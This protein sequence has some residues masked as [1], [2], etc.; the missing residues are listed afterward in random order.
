MDET[1]TVVTERTDMTTDKQ[2]NS[3]TVVLMTPLKIIAVRA[4][5][6]YLQTLV[7]LLGAFGSGAAA[8]VGVNITAGDFFH[9]VVVCAG[10]SVMPAAMS[11]LQ[12][13]LELFKK[14][15]ASYPE[16]RA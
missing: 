2:A 5:R 10:L 15:D 11:V 9:T 4:T 16:L 14:L 1:K 13:T 7:G 12:N 8:M 6:V 3:V